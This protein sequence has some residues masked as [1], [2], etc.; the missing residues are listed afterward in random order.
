MKIVE[1][2]NVK[3]LDESLYDKYSKGLLT[4]RKVA[5]EFYKHGWTNFID[6]DYATRVM[7]NLKDKKQ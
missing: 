6:E 5:I 7:N 2:Y 3:T 4:I 1:E